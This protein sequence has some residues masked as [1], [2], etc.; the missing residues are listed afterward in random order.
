MNEIGT[1]KKREM[2]MANARNLRL[3]P[4][5]TYIS[6]TCVGVRVRGYANFLIC[7]A[8]NAKFRVGGLS[9][10]KNPT[11]MFLHRSGI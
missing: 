9:Q 8:G 1:K 6:L 5:T 10:R 2:Y 4:N 11:Q 7:V 3:G